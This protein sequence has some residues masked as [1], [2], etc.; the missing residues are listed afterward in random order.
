[1]I[2]A[3]VIE[4]FEHYMDHGGTPVTRAEFEANLAAKLR[5]K[6]FLDDITPLLPRDATYDV[7]AAD[8]H[9]REHLIATLRGDP[10]KGDG[11]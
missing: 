2:A 3:K 7:A 6:Q 9:V 4:C 8:A 5:S 10:W 1:M 11:G